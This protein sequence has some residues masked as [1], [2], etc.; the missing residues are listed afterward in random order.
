MKFTTSGESHGKGLVC[1]IEGMPAGLLIDEQ[2]INNELTR[3]QKGYGRGGRM[4]IERDKIEIIGGVRDRKTLGSPIS[5]IIWNND[6]ENWQ[7]IMGAGECKGANEKV[8]TRPRPGH[9][10]L[11]GAI[12]YNHR[13]MRNVLERASARE[14]AV[15]VAAGAFFK[16]LLAYFNIYIYSQV[17]SI[18][19]VRGKPF[20]VC[21]EN[22]S[23]L[24]EKT[25]A[26]L[27]G[28]PD[29]EGEKLMIEAI[30]KARSSGESL[31]GS[32]EV[33][34]LGAIPGLGSHT[35]W[36]KR[37]D[38]RL[39]GLIMSIP[40]IK[41]VEIGEGIANSFNS[42][43]KVHDEIFY[44]QDKGIYRKTNR[45]GGIE[46]GITNGET[47]W[48]R[49]Y[50][51]PI[52]TLYKPLNSIDTAVWQEEKAGVERSDVCA[53]PAAAVVAEAMLAYGI[54]EAF[55]DKFGHDNIEHIKEA[56]ENYIKYMGREWKWKRI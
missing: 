32:F 56:Y 13:D 5:F 30:E 47:V 23:L 10:D 49:A 1:V 27:V 42:G 48:L 12:K 9:A 38:G 26:S 40:A 18:G 52:P 6:H 20:E 7:D 39:A 37:L 19:D 11:P 45:A 14:T 33:G 4:K 51:K 43:S 54:A 22:L 41:A 17:I 36:D 31:G 24:W 25:N 44:S 16:Q 53:V 35:S 21:R 55:L 34:A 8:L 15:R 50:M 2:Y 29:E 28:C 46:G 3:R